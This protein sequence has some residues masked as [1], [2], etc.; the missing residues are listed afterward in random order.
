VLNLWKLLKFGSSAPTCQ[1]SAPGCNFAFGQVIGI[2]SSLAAE[3][4]LLLCWYCRSPVY[5]YH[6]IVDEQK[7]LAMLNLKIASLCS[8]LLL[9]LNL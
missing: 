3:C 9:F 6:Q 8:M 7:A 1:L 4:S 5:G 2:L